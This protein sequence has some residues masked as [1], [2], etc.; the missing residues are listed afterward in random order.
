[1]SK[2][3]FKVESWWLMLL[4]YIDIFQM[5][6][7]GAPLQVKC[8][9]SRNLRS[10]EKLFWKKLKVCLGGDKTEIYLEFPYQT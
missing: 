10:V 5:I 9:I 8:K 1:M 3:N 6:W 4:Q 2:G 7:N